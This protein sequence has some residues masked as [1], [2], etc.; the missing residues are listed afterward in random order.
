M[1][2]TTETPIVEFQGEA[3]LKRE[4]ADL[5]A[6]IEGLN[7]NRIEWSERCLKAEARIAELTDYLAQEKITCQMHHRNVLI[8]QTALKASEASAASWKEKAIEERARGNY[9]LDNWD[10]LPQ[11]NRDIW[12]QDASRELEEEIKDV[13]IQK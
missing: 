5:K 2:G 13:A 10:L 3:R 11:G 9:W 1:I 7:Q 12:L 6:Q 4:I 8:L